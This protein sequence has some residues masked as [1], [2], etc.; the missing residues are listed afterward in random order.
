VRRLSLDLFAL[1]VAEA[2]QLAG[3]PL[4]RVIAEAERIWIESFR[5]EGKSSP[6]ARRA[7]YRS[8]GF[9]HRHAW[10]LHE[11]VAANESGA[12]IAEVYGPLA[13]RDVAWLEELSQQLGRRSRRRAVTLERGA[14]CPACVA[15]DDIRERKVAFLVDVLGLERARDA[16]GRSDGLCFAHLARALEQAQAVDLG[17]A[18]FLVDDWRRRL[19]EVGKQ[20]AEFDRKRDARYAGEPKGLEQQSWTDVIRMYAGEPG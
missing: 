14:R 1:E 9:C 10:L 7:F 19:E 6:E 3:C 11:L 4:C 5:R 15:R 17:I 13:E 2:L 20:L 16:Y 18:R 8:G 12:S